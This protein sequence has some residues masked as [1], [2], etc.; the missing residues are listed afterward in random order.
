M[1]TIVRR[2][3]RVERF[4]VVA[5]LVFIFTARPCASSDALD[6]VR[7]LDGYSVVHESAVDA[8]TWTIE[9]KGGLSI[10]FEA[11]F[12]EGLW[13]DPK[14]VHSYAWTRTQTVNGYKVLFALIKPG[15]KTRWEP[16][17][18]R[19]FPPGNILLVT[20]LLDGERSFHTA[21]FSAKIV[22]DQE[23]VDALLMVMTFDPSK[24]T[25]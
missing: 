15:L 20:F 5:V 13:V 1:K 9:K 11:G 24:G 17:N 4:L 19:G 3:E 16:Q 12:S 10:H 7:L 23:L 18:S 21:N 2:N 8:V 6:S 25:Y 14:D 22:G